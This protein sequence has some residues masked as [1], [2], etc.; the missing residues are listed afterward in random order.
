MVPASRQAGNARLRIAEFRRAELHEWLD[1][2]WLDAAL[3]RVSARG[4]SDV[5]EANQV[6]LTAIFAEFLL[7]WRTRF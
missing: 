3:A 4:P 7:W 2:D 1:L 6:Q 5:G